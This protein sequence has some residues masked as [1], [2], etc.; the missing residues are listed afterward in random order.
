ALDISAG[1]Y[2]SFTRGYMIPP[3]AREDG[4]LVPFAERV[5][6][7]V[8]VPVIAVGKLRDPVHADRIVAE[9]RADF[10]A[11]G[12]TLLADPDWP[13]KAREGRL[14]EINRCIACNQGCI[15][16]LFDQKD[17]WC[18]VNPETSREEVFAVAP[19][20]ALRITDRKSTRLNSSHVKISYAVF[21]LKKKN[22]H[23]K[24][25]S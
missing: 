13:N 3:M 19:K 5:K 6:G 12:R 11:I 18:T 24:T 1:N 16:R 25:P 7:E 8:G 23:S 17:V 4:L 21:C 22:N 15:A 9:G 20:R 10:V 14:E 2:A